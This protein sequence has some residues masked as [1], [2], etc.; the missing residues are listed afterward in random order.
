MDERIKKLAYNLVNYSCRVKKGEKVLISCSGIHP[1]PLVKQ[2]IK[3]VYAVGGL[4][5]V[6]FT[7]N[8]IDRELLMNITEEQLKLMAECSAMKMKEMDAY[9]GVRGE[10]NIAEM[11]DVPAEKTALYDR[12]YMSPYT[13]KY[14]CRKPN[15]SFF[16][17]LRRQWLRVR[18]RV[19]NHLKITTSMSAISIIAKC[20]RLWTP[21]SML[22][23]KTDKVRLTAKDT[24]ITFSI[25]DI[26]AI[27]CAGECNI[28]DGEVY[29][30]PVKTSINGTITYNTPSEYNNFK[31]ENVS[32]TFK[33]GKIVDCKGNDTERLN[34]VFNTDAGARYIGEFAIGVNP[35][36]TKPM[37]NI[38]F[39]E[40]IMEVFT[41]LPVTATMT[42]TTEISPLS[43]GI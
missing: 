23:N 1:M 40:K 6:D 15:G 12:L 26:P 18:I 22:M 28:P 25:K 17:I 21:L 41:S 20:R 14:E 30:A 42:H 34:Q 9:I 24:D 39:D 31:F 16:A 35:Y 4:P 38:L 3:E 37:N 7:T 5:F 2:L 36:I 19:W 43:T 13:M 32:L 33:D 10:D 8:S 11:S 27:K 29:T